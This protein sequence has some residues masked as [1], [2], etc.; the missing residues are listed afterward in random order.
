M[1]KKK[2]VLKVVL[3]TLTALNHLILVWS[4]CHSEHGD[5]GDGDGDHG[6]GDG[7]HGD[8]DHGDGDRIRSG[9]L[10]LPPPSWQLS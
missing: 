5:H 4:H 1:M 3:V 7:D 6:D 8:G 10:S 9:S 2:V